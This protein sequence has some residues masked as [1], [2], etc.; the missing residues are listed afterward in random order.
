MVLT[1]V[2][3]WATASQNLIT[4]DRPHD[5]MA[6]EENIQNIQL[7]TLRIWTRVMYVPPQ[8]PAFVPDAAWVIVPTVPYP[9]RRDQHYQ[10][11]V[12]LKM[13]LIFLM[14]LNI[15]TFANNFF[16]SST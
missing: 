15:L 14:V 12:S 4:E 8:P 7:Y 13:Q 9:V 6:W 11:A 1:Y 3:G 10:V 16:C 5:D 2:D